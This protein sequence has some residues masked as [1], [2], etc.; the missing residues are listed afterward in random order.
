[1]HTHTVCVQGE[2]KQREE[3]NK[4]NKRAGLV[5][6]QLQVLLTEQYT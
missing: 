6:W 3:G 4:T 2:I 1:M 5:V